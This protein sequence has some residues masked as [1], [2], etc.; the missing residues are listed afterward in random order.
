MKIYLA[1]KSPRRRSLL[2]QIGIEYTCIEGDIDESPF[3]NE[4]PLDYV[5][6]MAREKAISGWDNPSRGQ[7][8]PLLAADTS[9]IF[10]NEILGKP[11]NQKQAF[12]MLNKLSGNTHQV[13]TAVA[14]KKEE[15]EKIVV[16]ITH[17]TFDSLSDDIINEYISSGDCFD[18]AGA[19]GI[20][21][22]AARFVKSISGSYT[23][24][25]GLPL[26]ETAN[27]LESF[28]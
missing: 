12:S 16:S 13:I 9:V 18:K 6:R 3:R 25:V 10:E 14:V 11:D 22:Y 27:L 5:T 28:E 1:S 23:G 20:Q 26:C 19:Y 2:S 17:V 21:N 7:A 8:M 15:I 24:V 4:K